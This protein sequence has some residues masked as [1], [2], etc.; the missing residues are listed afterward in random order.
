MIFYRK[1]SIRNELK[2]KQIKNIS[3]SSYIDNSCLWAHS[4]PLVKL[5]PCSMISLQVVFIRMKWDKLIVKDAVMVH[6]FLHCIVLGPKRPIAWHVLT[7]NIMF[8][9]YCNF[10]S[11]WQRLRTLPTQSDVAKTTL[12]LHNDNLKWMIQNFTRPENRWTRQKWLLIFFWCMFDCCGLW[13][14]C[15]KWIIIYME[16]LLSSDW[17]R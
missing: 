14:A 7:V 1:H 10:F 9:V 5:L 6:L 17:L 16:K 4:N 12:F 13:Y 11:T 15:I 8:A 3:Q 2:T